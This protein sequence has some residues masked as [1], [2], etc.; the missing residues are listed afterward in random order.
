MSKETLAILGGKKLGVL[1]QPPFPTF[2]KRAVKRVA[3][4]LE[5]GQVLGLGL[6][7]PEIKEA[8]QAISKFHG[9][10]HAMGTASGHGAL[11]SSLAGL[12]VG[13]GDEVITTPYTWGASISCILH[14]NAIPIFA[15]VKK[16]TGLLDPDTIEALITSRTKAI[17]VVHIYGQPADMTKIMKIARKH[18]L[19]V[20]E[21]G[22]Q[23]HG[24][25]WKGTPVGN[26]GD[27]AGFSCMGGKLLATIEAGYMVTPHEEV[28]WRGGMIGQHMGRLQDRSC[29]DE[30][31]P[32]TD[33]LV[34][35][36]RMNAITAVLLSEQFKK[37]PREIEGR[38]QNMALL[39]TYL[40][41]AK[42]MKLPKYSKY[43]NPAYH[44]TTCNFNFEAA[45]IRRETF[46]KA[47]SA[48]GFGIGHY[49]PS[50]IHTWKRINWQGYKGPQTMWLDNLKRAKVD[51]RK[52]ET[53][54]CQY[55]IDHALEFAFNYYKPNQKA[56]QRLADIVY[57]VEA[58]ID[59]LRAYEKNI[60]QQ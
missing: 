16:D 56:M 3:A 29:V 20:V 52:V 7:S 24:A 58:N 5:K 32:Y 53:P 48:E 11:Q 35:T 54:N 14:Q 17:L 55:K 30:L 22:S 27:A 28:L 21:D 49:V 36:Y 10:L 6:S 44:I 60:S 15:D 12:E 47:L 50:P 31:K 39:T 51:Y 38:R 43:A 13:P 57:K 37:L 8:E 40:K 2:S 46:E 9:G 59:A 1:A 25:T 19:V 45:G 34:Y 23:A 18:N 4:N 41:D 42:Y 33:S 26:F